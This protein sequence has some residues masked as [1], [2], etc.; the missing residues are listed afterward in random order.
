MDCAEGAAR[1]AS[2]VLGRRSVK[3]LTALLMTFALAACKDSGP[4]PTAA[5]Q[6]NNPVEP[7]PAAQPP[8][9]KAKEVFAQRCVPCH[10]ATGQGDGPASATLDPKPR[11][12]IDTEWQA[13]VTDDYLVK[14]IKYGGAA[15]G[16]SAA[17]PNNPDL[18]DAV[19]ASLKDIVRAFGKK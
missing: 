2:R 4:M 5:S 19:V 10:G 15:V 11:K 1:L 14:I 3:T 17:M 9:E 8:A 13:S 12:Y 16:K 6:S 7:A 18:D